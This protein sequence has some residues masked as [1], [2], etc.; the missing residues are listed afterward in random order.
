MRR[1]DV[2][3]RCWS[4]DGLV[5]LLGPLAVCERI[6]AEIDDQRATAPPWRHRQEPRVQGGGDVRA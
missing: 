2:R 4:M 3:S 1:I 5:G 6:A